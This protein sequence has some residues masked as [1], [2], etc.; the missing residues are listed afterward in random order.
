MGSLLVEAGR[1]R[2]WPRNETQARNP[3]DLGKEGE[4]SER[5]AFERKNDRKRKAA[6]AASE[7]RVKVARR[8][9]LKKKAIWDRPR[10]PSSRPSGPRALKD[11][12][13]VDVHDTNEHCQEVE[14]DG[15]N[16][17]VLRDLEVEVDGENQEVLRDL[18]GPPPPLLKTE[19]SGCS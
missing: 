1:R 9:E 16:R 8:K 4:G 7:K 18:E 6:R 15:E 14:V 11:H 2:W 17:E 5:E 19:S 13:T 12:L 10:C 3:G